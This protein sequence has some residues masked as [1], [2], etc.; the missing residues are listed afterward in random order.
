MSLF[1]TLNTGAAGM[2]VSSTSLSVVVVRNAISSIAYSRV[3]STDCLGSSSSSWPSR[4]AV[5]P[6]PAGKP[7]LAPISWRVVVSIVIVSV[8]LAERR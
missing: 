4:P 2:G 7:T 5:M 3:S 6:R 8:L 1:N